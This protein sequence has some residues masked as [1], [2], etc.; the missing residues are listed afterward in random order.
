MVDDYSIVEKV[1]S[2]IMRRQRSKSDMNKTY[3]AIGFRK[4]AFFLENNE[5][6]K[7]LT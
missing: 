5:I 7:I 4:L 6:T 2:L 1:Y 3:R